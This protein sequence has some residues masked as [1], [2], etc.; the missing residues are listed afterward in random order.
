MNK[1]NSKIRFYIWATALV[2]MILLLGTGLILLKYHAGASVDSLVLG[3]D[4]H[5]WH[6]FHTLVAIISTLMVVLHLFVKTNWMRNL[7]T[8]KLKGRFKVAN[9]LLFVIFLLCSCTAFSSWLIFGNAD[10]SVLLRGLH[11]KFGLLLIVLFLIHIWN[12]RKV[13]LSYL[14]KQK[15]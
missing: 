1:S 5:F 3:Q 9:V 15:V 2:P 6:S 12:Y 13:I 14:R 11:N 4:G 7:L 10:I 8:F